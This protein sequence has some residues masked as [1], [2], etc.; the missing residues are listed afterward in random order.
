[1]KFDSRLTLFVLTL[2]F[3]ATSASCASRPGES[4]SLASFTENF[5]RVSIK[6]ERNSS[7]DYLLS[8]RF[9]PPEGYHLYSKDI[10]LTGADG[11]GRPTLLELTVDSRM[12][13]TGELKESVEAHQP[14]FEPKELLV[15]PSGPVTLSLP[16]QLPAGEDWLDDEVKITY[17][18]C[19]A[20][21]CK[22]PVVGK[23]L[24]VRVPG[25]D[26]I[27]Q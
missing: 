18:T 26:V 5:V 14:G 9:T 6:L 11:L 27:D 2:L 23:I 7:G 4:I 1:M 24:S 10:P 20:V 13:A 17:M 25:A 15:Y 19:S 8:A 16:V 12:S 21:Q 3:L 22:R